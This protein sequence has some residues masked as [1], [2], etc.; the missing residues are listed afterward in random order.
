MVKNIAVVYGGNSYEHEISI[1]TAIECMGELMDSGYKIYPIYLRER[2][3]YYG[4]EL[5]NIKIYKN[6]KGDKCKKIYFKKGKMFFDNCIKISRFVANIDCCI[7]CT[8]G[9]DGE[10]GSL[11]GYFRILG[12]PTT[13][14]SVLGNSISMD[15]AVTKQFLDANSILSAKY[16]ALNTYRDSLEDN[17]NLVEKKLSYPLVIKPS[18]GGSSIG[19]R[20]AHNQVELMEG[21]DFSSK[22][23][24]SVIVEEK[25]E[26]FEEINIA[27]C[28]LENKII[29]SDIEK[30]CLKSD[31]LTFKDKYLNDTNSLGMTGQ[32]R[33]IPYAVSKDINNKI[34]AIATK[35]YENLNFS[36]VIRIDMFLIKGNVLLNEINAIPGSLS[37]YLFDNKGLPY[38]DFLIG[39]T[40]QAIRDWNSVKSVKYFLGEDIF[41]KLNIN[42]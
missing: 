31:I 9:G 10:D 1:L 6:F 23:C 14:Q 22:F 38:K 25:L 8:H 28:R 2:E 33:I 41:S 29:L 30:V 15:K 12:I 24:Q 40:E 27:V 3:F 4:E 32:E 7:L 18:N 5:L 17:I 11:S 37:Y 42:K 20:I 13:S 34:V 35:I 21:I 36:G 26:N 39:L 16:V 19:I